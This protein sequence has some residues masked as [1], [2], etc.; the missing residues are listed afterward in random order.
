MKIY[1]AGVEALKKKQR[2]DENLVYNQNW[3]KN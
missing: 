3:W 2:Q 1:V